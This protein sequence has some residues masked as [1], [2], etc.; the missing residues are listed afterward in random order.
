MDGQTDR[1][2][3]RG[4][5]SRVK[6][7]ICFILALCYSQIQL[8]AKSSIMCY[9]A[10]AFFTNITTKRRFSYRWFHIDIFTKVNKAFSQKF[11][12]IVTKCIWSTKPTYLIF[13]KY[14]Y[15]NF[16]HNEDIT[17]FFF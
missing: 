13:L 12:F 7:S 10:T 15:K 6:L 5:S 2:E 1:T 16:F 17:Q 14:F 4:S 11:I 9:I 3:F 8:R